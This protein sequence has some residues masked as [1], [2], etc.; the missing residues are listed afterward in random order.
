[1]SSELEKHIASLEER[2]IKL[3]QAWVERESKKN[4]KFQTRCIQ[5]NADHD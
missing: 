4:R 5:T 3:E 2:I 1:M